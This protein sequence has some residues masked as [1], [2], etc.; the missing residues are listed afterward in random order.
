MIDEVVFDCFYQV[1]FVKLVIVYQQI[2]VWFVV[3]YM[4]QYCFV[5]E[6]CCW[7]GD[8]VVGLVG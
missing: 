8:V 1:G 5:F 7:L 2:V 3:E 6:E 4:C